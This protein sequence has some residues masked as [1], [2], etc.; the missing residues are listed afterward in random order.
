MIKVLSQIKL[1]GIILILRNLWQV[2]EGANDNRHYQLIKIL[3]R[4]IGAVL[5]KTEKYKFYKRCARI[6]CLKMSNVC[7]SICFK[8]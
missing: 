3:K 2:S 7:L 6:D 4:S 5:K 1:T 8:T